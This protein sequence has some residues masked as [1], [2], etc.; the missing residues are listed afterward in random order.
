MLEKIWNEL[1]VPFSYRDIFQK[2]YTEEITVENY[3]EMLEEI[4][5][6][7]ECRSLLIEVL[8]MIRENYGD[9]IEDVDEEDYEYLGIES[10]KPKKSESEDD[11]E[12]KEDIKEKLKELK[13]KLNWMKTL[14]VDGKDYFS[15]I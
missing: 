14:V 6:M 1:N 8:G 2:Q 10:N 5:T 7:K 15:L 4:A 11:F 12:L 3:L 13:S 9:K